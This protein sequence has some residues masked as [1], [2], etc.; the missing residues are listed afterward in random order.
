MIHAC[1]LIAL[2]LQNFKKNVSKVNGGKDFDEDMLDEI[3][4]AIRF[5]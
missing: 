4:T 3:Y 2:F 1:N 5:G